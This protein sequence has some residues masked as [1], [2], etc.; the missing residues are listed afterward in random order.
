MVHRHWSWAWAA[1]RL[2]TFLPLVRAA[3][4]IT[5]GELVESFLPPLHRPATV[6]GAALGSGI[7]RSTAAAGPDNVYTQRSCLAITVAEADWL[8]Y[9]R[10]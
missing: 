4:E 6:V 7:G 2:R 10:A 5:F 8:R 1:G 3:E 9:P